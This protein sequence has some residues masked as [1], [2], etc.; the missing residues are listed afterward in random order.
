MP[1]KSVLVKSRQEV[2][3]LGFTLIELM[4]VIAIIGILAAI[5]I[6]R[7]LQYIQSARI[8]A[9]AA[10][11]RIAVDATSAAFARA[12][13]VNTTNILSTINASATIG[14]PF[15]HSQPEFVSGSATDCGQIGFTPSVITPSTPSVTI[16]LG[17]NDCSSTQ[18]EEDLIHLLQKDGMPV[19]M[20]AGT[21]T[22][23]ANDKIG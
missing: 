9:I 2:G 19:T 21:I 16:N 5:A 8:T 11:T 7:Y 13:S 20:P 22:V 1:G 3:A 23:T 18:E 12:K 10:D 4:I 6:P 17:G 15:Q 14:D